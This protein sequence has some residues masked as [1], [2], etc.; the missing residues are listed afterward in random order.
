MKNITIYSTPSCHFCV[1][2]KK[3]LDGKGIR[4]TAIDLVSQPEKREEMLKLT[5]QMGVPVIKIDDK[6][7][8]GFNRLALQRE[9]DK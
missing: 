5:G 2:A 9:L 6:V 8:I 3:F 7:L 4:Y 1:E